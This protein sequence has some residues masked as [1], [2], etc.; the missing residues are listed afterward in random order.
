MRREYRALVRLV[1]YQATT[2]Y[3][4]RRIKETLDHIE[5]MKAE[6]AHEEKVLLRQRER[7]ETLDNKP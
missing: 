7:S 1:V 4:A 6:E 5:E 3:G 2:I